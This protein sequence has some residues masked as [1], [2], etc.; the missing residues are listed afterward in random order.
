MHRAVRPKRASSAGVVC[1]VSAGRGSPLL[2]D[3]D[4]W[5][6]G[7]VGACGKHDVLAGHLLLAPAFKVHCYLTLAR[8]LAPALDVGDLQ[9][10]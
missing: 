9:A 4:A 1:D 3:L 7:G 6:V 5:E 8:D 10:G 2:V